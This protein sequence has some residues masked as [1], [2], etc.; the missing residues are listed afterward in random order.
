MQV[1]G[2]VLLGALKSATGNPLEQT[3]N[4]KDPKKFS[5]PDLP[6]YVDNFMSLKK[7]FLVYGKFLSV[8]SC[9]ILK[10]Y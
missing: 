3:G 2:Q 8:I 1:P 6:K 4:K 5:F 9:Y 7:I 10:N